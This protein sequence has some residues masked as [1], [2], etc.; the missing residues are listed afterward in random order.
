MGYIAMLA[1]GRLSTSHRHRF[2]YKRFDIIAALIAEFAADYI[3]M[4]AV[5]ANLPE[6]A[7]RHG[8]KKAFIPFYHLEIADHK[9]IIKG[10]S[11]IGS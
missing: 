1:I 6:L 2:S 11:G 8:Y 3:S 5:G 9:S 10:Y 7:R 4:P